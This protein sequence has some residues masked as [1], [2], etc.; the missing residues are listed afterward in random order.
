MTISLSICVD[1]YCP[2]R[3][4]APCISSNAESMRRLRIGKALRSFKRNPFVAS[5]R[6]RTLAAAQLLQTLMAPPADQSL[7]RARRTPQR[8]GKC[9]RPRS[10]LTV[11]SDNTWMARSVTDVVYWTDLQ[12]GHVRA[13]SIVFSFPFD[14]KERPLAKLQCAAC[15]LRRNTKGYTPHTM[16]FIQPHAMIASGYESR[17]HALLQVNAVAY[18]NGLQPSR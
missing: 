1:T 6:E 9:A 4:E 14:T 7:R 18:V 17:I 2:R 12:A 15:V 3:A 10:S 11:R 5:S 13:C 8:H 16:V